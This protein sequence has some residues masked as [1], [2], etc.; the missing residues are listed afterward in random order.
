MRQSKAGLKL[1]ANTTQDDGLRD[2]P[3]CGAETPAACKI[4]QLDKTFNGNLERNSYA[5][6][7]CQCR[8]LVYISPLPSSG[9]LDAIYLRSE[10]FTD[11]LYSDPERVAAILRYIGGCLTRILSYKKNQETAVTELPNAHHQSGRFARTI[12][13]VTYRL[14]VVAAGLRESLAA[15]S[16]GE[17]SVLEIGAGRAWMC[18]AAKQ[19]NPKARTVAQDVSAETATSCEW[20][21]QFLV[22][23]IEDARL[24]SLGRF[25][26]ISMTHVIEHLTDPLAALKRCAGLLKPGG[27][28][29]VTAPHRPIGWTDADADIEK[30]RSYS[31]NHI[32]AHIQYFSRA[33]MQKIADLSGLALVEW[34]DHHEDGQAL[35]AWLQRV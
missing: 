29:F 13:R 22:C 16:N 3:V 5:L 28:L 20:V 34:S 9:D 33:A 27:I 17:L 26:I 23:G 18:R 35:E 12:Q 7:Y 31:Y 11:P 25:D 8:S 2:C 24:D 6:T 19:I 14:Q 21:D 32:P 30:W 15:K 4:G 1:M 10:Q